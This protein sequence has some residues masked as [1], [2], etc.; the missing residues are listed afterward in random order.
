MSKNYQNM[1]MLLVNAGS[2]RFV[3]LTVFCFHVMS[4]YKGKCFNVGG[5]QYVSS[6]EYF[7]VYAGHMVLLE[8]LNLC[9]HGGLGM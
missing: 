5:T 8:R 4:Y 1:Q 2:F 3:S 7:A 6:V 9:D